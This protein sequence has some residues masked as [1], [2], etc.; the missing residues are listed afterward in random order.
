ML[1]RYEHGGVTW[2]DLENPTTDEVRRVMEE[3]GLNHFVAEELLLPTQKPRVEFHDKYLYVILHFPALRHAHKT[4]EQEVDF[5]VGEKFLITTHYDTID[6]L[7]KF[8]KVFEVNSVLDK[9]PMGEHAGYL[10]F[11]MLRRLYK[12]VE[13]ELDFVRNDLVHIEHNLFGG[14]EVRMVRAISQCARD[15][16]LVFELA[17]LL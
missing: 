2:V 17:R 8:S 5:V 4:E 6:P 13:H 12:A 15:Y 11:Y 3:Y 16:W 7:H 10:F 1:S 9:S 14:L